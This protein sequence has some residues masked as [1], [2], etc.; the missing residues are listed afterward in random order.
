MTHRLRLKLASLTFAVL[1]T[2]W[3]MWLSSPL[4]PAEIVILTTSGMLA[5]FG[6]HWLYGRWYRWHFARKSFPRKRTT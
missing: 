1:W 2:G 3:M 5:G 6:W 4:R